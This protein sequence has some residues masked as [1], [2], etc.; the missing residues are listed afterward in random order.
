MTQLV[1]NAEAY[2]FKLFKENLPSIYIYHN[3]L[4]TQRVVESSA[5]ILENTDVTD[6]EKEIVLL[7]AWFH[8]SGY[9]KGDENHEEK[10]V[11][12][13]EEFLKK[14]KTKNHIIENVIRCIRVTKNGEKPTT[15]LEEIIKD[16]DSSHFAKDYFK[17]VSELLR[18]EINLLGIASYGAK[19]WR[20]ENIKLFTQTHKYYTKYAILNWDPIKNDHLIS[21]LKKNKK[22]KK[23]QKKEVLKAQLKAKYKDQSPERGIQTLYRVTLRNHIKLSDIADTKANILLSVNAIIISLA[24]ANL[25]PKLDA[26]SNKHLLIPSLVLVLFSVASIILSIMSTQPKVTGGEFTQEQ[27]KN[28][29]VNLLFFGNFYKMPYEKYQKAI[30][31]VIEDKQYVY[32]M[33][34]KD[35]YLLGLVLK[36]KYTLLKTTYIVF[37]IGIILSVIAFII[38]FWGMEWVNEVSTTVL[39]KSTTWLS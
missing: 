1:D 32:Q 22:R 15:L 4:H 37:M 33:L 20:D 10:S 26:P 30:D 34:T 27:V 8:D 6:E 38:A 28:K 5:E 14:H 18:Q 35:L 7:A 17:D 11:L 3:F 31:Q 36:K 21:L 19:E 23:K 29:K 2:I 13:A 12:I 25:I 39:I 24:L 16:A 9:V